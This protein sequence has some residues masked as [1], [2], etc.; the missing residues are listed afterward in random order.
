MLSQFQDKKDMEMNC[1]HNILGIRWNIL[2]F[3]GNY[4]LKAKNKSYD[5]MTWKDVISQTEITDYLVQLGQF[6]G[7]IHTD[8]KPIGSNIC[9]HRNPIKGWQDWVKVQYNGEIMMCQILVFLEVTT[10]V[11]C[12][13]TDLEQGKYAL[14]HFINQDVFSNT[15]TKTLYG[16]KYADFLVDGN[17][18]LV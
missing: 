17:C 5:V 12:N 15:P 2:G 7:F 6:K 8:Y 13:T 18:E 3:N 14:V 10:V 16:E 4:I 11:S 9:Y 1:G